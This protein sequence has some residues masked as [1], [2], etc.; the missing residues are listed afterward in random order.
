MRPDSYYYNNSPDGT[1]RGLE[2]ALV[3]L[4]A[5]LDSRSASQTTRIIMTP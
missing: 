5:V 2:L 4:V 3:V 1:S